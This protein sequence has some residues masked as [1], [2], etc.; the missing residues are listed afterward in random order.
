MCSQNWKFTKK[1]KKWIISPTDVIYM[2]D[3]KSTIIVSI[4]SIYTCEW[5]LSKGATC[6]W[7]SNEGA[8]QNF[9]PLSL[10]KIFTKF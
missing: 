5:A 3:L 6:F 4:F 1:L 2:F 7:S 9:V 8:S 10:N